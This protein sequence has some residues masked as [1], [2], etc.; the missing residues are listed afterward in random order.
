MNE[1]T[2]LLIR[3][4]M[5]HVVGVSGHIEVEGGERITLVGGSGFFIAPFRALTARHVTQELFGTDPMRADDLKKRVHTAMVDGRTAY[6]GL[7]HS[8]ILYQGKFRA[9][10]RVFLWHVHNV[11]DSTVTDISLMEVNAEGDEAGGMEHQRTGYFEWALLPPP[12]GSH[13]TMIGYPQASIKSQDGL[14]EMDLKYV[15]Q[16]GKVAEVIDTYR[17]RGMFNFPCFR[18]DQPV[19]HGFSGG[20]VFWGERLCGIV[21]GGG[22][23]ADTYAASLWPLCLLEYEYPNLGELGRKRA[24]TDLFDSQELRSQDWPQIRERI[25]KRHHENGEAHAVLL[26]P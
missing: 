23:E 4:A 15:V 16:E 8:S 22:F 5:T 19:D 26:A 11:W 25:V 21:S 24:F 12:V 2:D 6:F 18:I 1:E 14:M 3:R 7:P 10:P 20:P 13:V 9:S 17:D